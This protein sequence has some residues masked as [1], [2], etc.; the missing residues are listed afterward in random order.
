M[1]LKK[2]DINVI[3]KTDESR[4]Q[5]NKCKSARWKVKY[6]QTKKKNKKHFYRMLDICQIIFS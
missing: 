4:L 3:F 2:V 1:N 6:K 5:R